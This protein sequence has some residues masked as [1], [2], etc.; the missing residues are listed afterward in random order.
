MKTAKGFK[1]SGSSVTAKKMSF[2][3]NMNL[4]SK[5]QLSCFLKH[6]TTCIKAEE[7]CEFNERFIELVS[8]IDVDLQ[9]FHFAA[10]T[11]AL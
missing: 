3:T 1:S 4:F 5:V 11:Q 10:Q 8:G 6:P 2:I 7:I 9:L